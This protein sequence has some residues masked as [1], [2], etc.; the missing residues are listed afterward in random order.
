MQTY[1]VS[2]GILFLGLWVME[3]LVIFE[4]VSLF[5]SYGLGPHWEGWTADFLLAFVLNLIAGAAVIAVPSGIFA[6]LLYLTA[7]HNAQPAGQRAILASSLV[8]VAASVGLTLTHVFVDG[9]PWKFD[10]L[11]L[12]SAPLMLRHDLESMTWQEAVANPLGMQLLL[13]PA[14]LL[15][16]IVVDRASQQGIASIEESI[17]D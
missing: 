17:G 4:T 1:L 13:T 7:R 6:A 3:G 14:L 10:M 15:I 5:L 12:F 2:L 8:F 9:W 11:M 16:C